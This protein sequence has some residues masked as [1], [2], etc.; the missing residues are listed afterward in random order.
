MLILGG[1]EVFVASPRLVFNPGIL[2]E[3]EQ[4]AVSQ[5][6]ASV[7]ELKK[8]Y[9]VVDGK[10]GMTEDLFNVSDFEKEDLT[11]S[12]NG[13]GPKVL[14]F[15]THSHEAF[16]DSR[17]GVSEDTIVGVGERLCRILENEYGI[18]CLHVTD[19]F[20]YVNG[21]VSILGAYERMEPV[22]RQY[23]KNN[24]TVEMV[25]DL[26]RDGVG[27]NTRLVT[28]VDGK[29]AAQ[30]MFFNGI[31]RIWEKGKLVAAEGLENPYLKAN[32][33]LSYNMKVNAD[34][35]YPGFARR[36]YINA[37]RYS[38]HFKPLSTLIELGAQTNT[39]EE[40]YNACEP[41]AAVIAK[42]VCGE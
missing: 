29:K 3:E 7:E 34:E 1:G 42:T 32:L 36:I 24:P 22:I 21:Q 20:D 35:M 33:A 31:C 4:I 40:A 13:G 25:I 17:A 19:R 26:H 11:I 16:A 15:H 14:L 2:F 18:E 5:N 10:T 6:T 30:V 28:E 12:K 8:R 38:T 23:L 39:V 37:Y 9:Y 27:E 41:L